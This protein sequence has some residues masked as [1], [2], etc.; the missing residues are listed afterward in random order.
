MARRD[1]TFAWDEPADVPFSRR[2]NI[3]ALYDKRAQ[4]LPRIAA[5]DELLRDRARTVLAGNGLDETALDEVVSA[6]QGLSRDLDGIKGKMIEAGRR[7]LRITRTAGA[8]GYRA[9]FRAGLVPVSEV[10]ASKLRKV[11][12]AVESGKIPVDRLPAAIRTAYYATTLPAASIGRLI[13]AGVLRPEATV[14]E[15]EYFLEKKGKEA[16]EEML[17][18]ERQRLMRRLQRLEETVRE[19]RRKLGL[20]DSA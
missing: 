5:E 8:S 3:V 13:D 19:L 15:I 7:L 16:A 12:E 9:L 11:A 2:E 10:T 14:R 18:S 6:L 20:P 17:P 4:A 1:S